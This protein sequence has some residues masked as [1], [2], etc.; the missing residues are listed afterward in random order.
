MTTF[1]CLSPQHRQHVT[2]HIINGASSVA[3]SDRHSQSSLSP[4]SITSTNSE[5]RRNAFPPSTVRRHK[6]RMTTMTTQRENNK[7]DSRDQ[8]SKQSFYSS[9]AS[10]RLKAEIDHIQS[11]L[12]IHH[13]LNKTS[14]LTPKQVFI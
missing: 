5:L 11:K 9:P 3:S 1:T 14:L 2:P 13:D 7:H 12:K 10:A 6:L 4:E 8:S